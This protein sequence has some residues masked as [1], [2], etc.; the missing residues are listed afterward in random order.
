MNFDELTPILVDEI[1]PGDTMNLTLNAFGRLSTPLVPIL[2]NLYVDYFF[3]Y[4]PS[5]LVWD[6][7]EKFNGAQDNPGD[8]TDYILPTLTA[9]AVTGFPVGSIYDH[10]GLPTGIPDLKINNALP[11]RCLNLI[12]NTWFRDENL[13]PGLAMAT[14]DGPDPNAYYT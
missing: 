14:D 5:R 8:S 11:L 1:L 13:T 12:W 3:F 10:M 4:V 7:W 2:D 9:P 6:N